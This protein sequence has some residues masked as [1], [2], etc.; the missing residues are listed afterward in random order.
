VTGSTV[1]GVLSGCG[2]KA[3]NASGA[4]ACTTVGHAS[5][6]HARWQLATVAAQPPKAIAMGP[7]STQAASSR[8][9]K[10]R[11]QLITLPV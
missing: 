6:V 8:R 2:F 9:L 3:A 7:I 10:T 1:T 4:M 11:R 5:G